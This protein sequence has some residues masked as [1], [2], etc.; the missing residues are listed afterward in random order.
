MISSINKNFSWRLAK[1]ATKFKPGLTP[2]EV[3]YVQSILG[4]DIIE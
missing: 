3:P 4:N 1:L 2:V